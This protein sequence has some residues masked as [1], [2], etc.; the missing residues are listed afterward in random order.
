M[1]NGKWE[2]V[3]VVAV[4]LVMIEL[5]K[6]AQIGAIR[7]ISFTVDF[8]TVPQSPATQVLWSPPDRGKW[9]IR[10][11]QWVVKGFTLMNATA[12]TFSHATDRAWG[13]NPYFFTL[14]DGTNLEVI[15]AGPFWGDSSVAYNLNVGESALIGALDD[16]WTNRL[17]YYS[18]VEIYSNEAMDIST[19]EN[20]LGSGSFVNDSSILWNFDLP[21]GTYPIPTSMT[22]NINVPYL[23]YS[24]TKPLVIQ[25]FL[26]SDTPTDTP[27]DGKI[28]FHATAIKRSN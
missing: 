18:P 13:A 25:Y 21:I 28:T 19:L 10:F 1:I 23:L 20:I 3:I 2:F 8:S 22:P 17:Q 26:A 9:S 27:L 12:G 24:R 14:G 6:G 11:V 16:S 7:E 15:M 5:T 4:L